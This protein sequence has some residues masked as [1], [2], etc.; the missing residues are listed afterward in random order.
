MPRSTAAAALDPL[1]IRQA[2]CVSRDR[3][4]RLLDVTPRT[5]QR[6]EQDR[7]LPTSRTATERLAQLREIIDLGRVVYSP[8][9]FATFL[10]TPIPALGLATPL[11]AIERWQ[12]DRVLALL[13]ADYEGVVS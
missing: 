3:M 6:S 9:G 5:V 11:Q 2:L 4:G 1:A 7:R 12:A 13:A 10:Q 8:D